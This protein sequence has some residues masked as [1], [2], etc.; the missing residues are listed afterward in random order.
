MWSSL[1]R[2]IG[3]LFS[4]YNRRYFKLDTL[5]GTLSYSENQEDI[6][7]N[8]SYVTKFG[9]ITGC[10]KGFVTMIVDGNPKR[11]KLKSNTTSSEADLGPDGFHHVF[12]VYLKDRVFTL[13]S[14]SFKQIDD[15]ENAISFVIKAKDEVND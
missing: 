12:E 5:K 6:D 7:N 4:K 3:E 11:I 15:F 10:K 9:N 8:P 14:D 2:S 13:Y 1:T